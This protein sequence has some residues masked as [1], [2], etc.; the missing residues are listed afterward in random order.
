MGG[1]GMPD[2]SIIFGFLSK[3]KDYITR[4]DL[5]PRMQGMFDRAT[6][7]LNITD[8][9]IT[10]DQFVSGM[11]KLKEMRARGIM[12]PGMGG[13]GGGMGGTP[14]TDAEK[15]QRTEQFAEM[16]FRERDQNQDGVLVVEEMS[17][18]LRAEREQWDANRDG[19][20]DLAEYKQF[21][22]AWVAKRDQ[23]RG[24]TPTAT[25]GQPTPNESEQRPTVYRAGKLP[26]ELPEWFAKLDTDVD[27]QVGLYEWRPSGK[28]FGEFESMDRNG[29]GLL[30]I[31]EVLRIQRI[32]QEKIAKANGTSPTSS[33]MASNNAL[34]MGGGDRGRSDR[35]GYSGRSGYGSPPSGM[36]PQSGDRSDRKSDRSE[37]SMT[38]ESGTSPMNSNGDRGSRTRRS[39]GGGLSP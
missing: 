10:R 26:K 14:Q 17:D 34:V 12:P 7:M 16:G 22:T 13:G 21:V 5:D 29:D 6:S 36:T 3:G 23:E 27:G 31:E 11:E 19:F 32:A 25:P 33:P 1:G 38:P 20:I 30:T 37:R 28:P 2:P 24:V 35:G 9:K 4:G 8:G 39:S 15:A 18:S